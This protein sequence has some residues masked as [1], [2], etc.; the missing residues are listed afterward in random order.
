MY[1]SGLSNLS[2]SALSKPKQSLG[3]LGIRLQLLLP[4][5]PVYKAYLGGDASLYP[6]KDLWKKL[7]PQQQDVCKYVCRLLG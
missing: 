1:R 6:Y 7:H 3:F 2:G 4:A 5:G